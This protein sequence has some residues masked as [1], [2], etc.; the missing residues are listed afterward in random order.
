MYVNFKSKNWS[1]VG[2]RG[3]FARDNGNNTITIK[4]AARGIISSAYIDELR[5]YCASLG[6]DFDEIRCGQSV[7]VSL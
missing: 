5:T 3:T 2:D 4:K 6:V 1:Y 7:T